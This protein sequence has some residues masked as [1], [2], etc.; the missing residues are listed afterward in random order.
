MENPTVT[1]VVPVYNVAS[2]IAETLESLLS[3]TFD[4]FE[5]LIVNDGTP[6]NSLEVVATFNDPRIRV[7]NQK[8]GGLNSARNTGIREGKGKYIAFLDADD[9]WRPRM[10]AMN[11]AHLEAKPEVG[12]SFT[13]SALIDDQSKPL[14]LR[15]RPKLTGIT[16][17]DVICRNPL[18]NG[19]A[20]VFRRE[21]FDGI[22]FVREETPPGQTWWFD[23]TFR[24]STDIECWMRI[25]AIT[26][27]KFEGLPE[28]LVDYR[29]NSGGLS[30][31][32]ERQ[33]MFWER[34]LAAVE[35]ERPQLV[36]RYGGLAR[37]YQYR[38]LARRAVSAKDGR[39][40]FGLTVKALREDA[41]IL[42]EEPI[43]TLTTMGAS[44]VLL[45]VGPFLN[46]GEPQVG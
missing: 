18:G 19:S 39:K 26:D 7:I 38:Y 22:A 30:A 45:F 14:G 9:L 34:G 15:Q 41:R 44:F 35:K 16:A 3:Q 46:R 4:D 40:A 10:L 21:V 43:K 17:R 24:Q 13:P 27:W 36:E 23:E 20:G 31:N 11:V 12:I 8:N 33:L 29:V 37:A 6:D 5:V 25:V 1:V 32:T 28:I 2:T 42:T